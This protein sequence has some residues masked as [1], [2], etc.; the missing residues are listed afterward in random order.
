MNGTKRFLLFLLL[1]A[2]VFSTTGCLFGSNIDP[3]V[4]DVNITVEIVHADGSEKK[5]TYT[6][7]AAKTL[8]QILVDEGLIPQGNIQDGM[9]TIVDGEE[10]IYER[11]KAY[12]AFYI[13]GDY[14]TVGICDA[15]I[16]DGA[17]YRL[18]YTL[19]TF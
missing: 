11:D 4:G 5:F 1:V 18:V 8:D 15:K 13:N 3:N 17:V 6:A 14:A 16:E 10:A 7:D 19:S 9:F 12:W 2:V